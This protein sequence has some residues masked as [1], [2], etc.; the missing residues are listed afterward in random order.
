[1]GYSIPKT[2]V[3]LMAAVYRKVFP[4]VS[5]EL[6]FWKERAQQIPDNELRNQALAS[7]ESK[8]FHCLGGAVYA[9][10]SGYRWQEAIRFIVAYQTI[11]DY[12]DNLC[13][14][15]TSMDPDDFRQLHQAM[16]DA[17]SPANPIKNYYAFRNE[18]TDG[19]YLADLVRTCQK[20][21][22]N[23]EYDVI[24]GYLSKLETLY[25]D[26][27]VHKHV[28]RDERVGRLSAWFRDN[29]S[30][31]PSLYWHEFSAAAGSTLGIFVLLPMH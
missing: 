28:R 22:R 9:L 18:Q 3:T 4:A 16:T 19:E 6:T 27:Q 11:S 15:S 30:A 2:P 25:S 5:K 7:I 29:A 21:M 1:M 8:R 13:D 17:L 26:L 14:R 12:L 31:S 20:T 10:L 23:L 24:K